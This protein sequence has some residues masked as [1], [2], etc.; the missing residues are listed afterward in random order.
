MAAAMRTASERCAVSSVVF[1]SR[2]ASFQTR[3]S[4]WREGRSSCSAGASGGYRQARSATAASELLRDI[5]NLGLCLDGV[6]CG[7]CGP[8]S[9]VELERVGPD[10]DDRS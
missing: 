5:R 3:G 9:L 8:S 1:A 10:H 4:A 7:Y 2:N 6:E